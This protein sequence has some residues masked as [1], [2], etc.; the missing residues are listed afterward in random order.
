MVFSGQDGLAKALT[1]SAEA[2]VYVLNATDLVQESMVRVETW[3]PAT[4]HLGQAMMAA[5]LLQAL[6][7]GKENETVSLQWMTDGP[8]GHL[9][10]EARN[11]GELRGTI[12]NPRPNVADY[13][14]KL[15][16]GVLQVRRAK[17]VSTTG[18]VPSVGDVSL[19]VVEYL[20]RSE[21]RACGINLS[22][23]IEWEDSAQTKFRVAHALGYLVHVLP[24]SDGKRAEEALLRWDRQMR[25]LGSISRWTLRSDQI[26]A[27]M[28]RLISLEE[29]PNIV[30][31]QRVRFSCH[32]NAER[33]TRALTML[34]AHEGTGTDAAEVKC[35]Y[36]GKT[37]QIARK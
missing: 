9:Y 17:H 29:S 31:Q 13:E 24:Q 28:L 6:S 35:E 34:D 18:L 33:A 26:L 16:E 7:E 3:P 14:T 2:V 15:G 8:F 30:L 10:A 37:Y 11:F 1:E 23:K 22:V 25:S 19:D 4:V 36:C 12:Q 5:A 21:Q 20:E 27:D 32:C